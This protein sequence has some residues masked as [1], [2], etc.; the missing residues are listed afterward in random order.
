MGLLLSLKIKAEKEKDH[1]TV[2]RINEALRDIHKL[3]LMLE[4]VE[5]LFGRKEEN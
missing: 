4:V 2:K 1:E 5:N 3:D